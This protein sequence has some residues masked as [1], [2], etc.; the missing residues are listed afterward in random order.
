MVITDANTTRFS[1]C[2]N[3][4]VRKSGRLEKELTG[5]FIPIRQAPVKYVRMSTSVVADNLVRL[6]IL[7]KDVKKNSLKKRKLKKR[8]KK[9]KKNQKKKQEKK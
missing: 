6:L 3:A 8:N 7:A 5:E 1:T 2:C 9:D 4:R